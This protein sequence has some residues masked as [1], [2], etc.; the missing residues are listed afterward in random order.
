MWHKEKSLSL[1]YAM[2][3][4]MKRFQCSVFLFLFF[5]SATAYSQTV[6]HMEN[7]DGVYKIPCEV[8]GMRMKFIFDTGAADVS[9]SRFLAEMMLDND[10]LSPNDIIGATQYQIADGSVVKE[11]V[12]VLREIKIGDSILRDIRASVSNSSEA[13]L[14]LG[15]SALQKLGRYTIV[16]NDLIL[17]SAPPKKHF[18]QATI[19]KY[20]QAIDKSFMPMGSLSAGLMYSQELYDAGALPFDYYPNHAELL[21]A[22][23][24]DYS[25]AYSL[26]I[27]IEDKW[28]KTFV[29][30]N[31]KLFTYY[32]RLSIACNDLG[33]NPLLYFEKA[34]MYAPDL[35]SEGCAIKGIV[36]YY[37]SIDESYSG[38]MIVLGKIAEIKKERGIKIGDCWEKGLRDE[39]V[40]MI[41]SIFGEATPIYAEKVHYMKAAAKWGWTPAIW[42]CQSERLSYQNM[43]MDWPKDY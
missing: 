6:V 38:D 12:I 23:N 13:P 14:L 35:T 32:Y 20:L 3:K 19:D 34:R 30:D 9:I 39:A 28:N 40:G 17:E 41:L 8:N 29:N 26:L 16:G 27:S 4:T 33:K 2:I 7:V 11:A 31:W 15:Q 43:P 22:V 36:D 18:S 10:Y 42:F 5:F 24:K 21:A 25:Q 1:R 37:Y